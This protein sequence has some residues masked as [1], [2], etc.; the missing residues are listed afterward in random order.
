MRE[1]IATEM[2]VIMMA[3]LSILGFAYR[4]LY[5]NELTQYQVQTWLCAA[6]VVLIMAPLGAHVLKKV[7]TEYMLRAVVVLN[8]GQLAY[9]NLRNPST[10]KFIWSMSGTGLMAALFFWGMSELAKRP[11]AELIAEPF[12]LPEDAGHIADWETEP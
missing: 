11:A 1:K 2:S 9:F 3:A 12:H 6:P 7:N 5:Q 8:I 10:E 4:G